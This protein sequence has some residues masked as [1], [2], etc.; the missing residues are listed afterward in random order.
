MLPT[1]VTKPRTTRLL[2]ALLALVLF[3]LPA[4]TAT[5]ADVYEATWSGGH[6]T[7]TATADFTAA[8]IESVS[9]SFDGCGTETGETGCTWEA[10][11]TLHSGSEH[12][13]PT[14]PEEQV[15]WDSGLQTGNG[16]VSGGPE[17]FALEGCR[18]QSLSMRL[19]HHKTYESGP[20]AESGGASIWGLFTFG[21]HPVEEAERRIIEA[22]PPATV[23][24]PPAPSLLTVAG[25]CRSLTA[26]GVSYVFSFRR[27]GCHKATNLAKMRHV[28]GRAPSGYHCRNVQ[29]NGGVICWRDGHR[30]KRLEWRLP[31]TKPASLPLPR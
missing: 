9:A 10:V 20:I 23:P 17:S 6:L 24:P 4:G 3:L 13:D 27:I 19:E 15:V 22:S 7:A 16:S 30:E 1:R 21:Y 28:S 18:G 31:G 25:D 11:A 2:P 12:C 29:A 26:D 8:T 5:A 14:T